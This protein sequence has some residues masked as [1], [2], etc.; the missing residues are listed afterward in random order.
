M[1]RLTTFS[2][3]P[4]LLH[5]CLEWATKEILAAGRREATANL[6]C[7]HV[8]AILLTHL[9]SVK[10]QPGLQFLYL[11]LRLPSAFLTSGFSVYV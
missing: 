3:I 4:F 1:S 2:R 8:D 6:W 11:P 9:V 5:F 10:Q 7:T